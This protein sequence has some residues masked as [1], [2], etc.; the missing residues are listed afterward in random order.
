MDFKKI[1]PIFIVLIMVLALVGVQSVSAATSQVVIYDGDR[2]EASSF[3]STTKEECLEIYARL[4]VDSQWR[5]WR[6]L[7][8]DVYD[9][10]GEQ[11]FH[12]KRLTSPITGYTGIGVWNNDLLKMK[13]GDYTVKVSYGGNEKEGWPP[14]SATAVIHHTKY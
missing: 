3:I 9:P 1:M 14:A 5:V 13:T 12:V 4:Y 6:N 7:E 2:H 8:F 10:N 11:L